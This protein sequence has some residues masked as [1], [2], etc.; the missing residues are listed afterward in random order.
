MEKERDQKLIE[1]ISG[2]LNPKPYKPQTAESVADHLHGRS[3]L[4]PRP[5]AVRLFRTV[6]EDKAFPLYQDCRD[7]APLMTSLPLG[8]KDR[9]LRSL[10]FSG[11]ILAG[12]RKIGAPG[13]CRSAPSVWPTASF[14]GPVQCPRLPPGV[15]SDPN[16]PSGKNN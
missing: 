6:R 5:P 16:L 15:S 1:Q 13:L 12:L 14:S 3:R 8:S 2:T 10:C 7:A 4:Q 11:P 9:P